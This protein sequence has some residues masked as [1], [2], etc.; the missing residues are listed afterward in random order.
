MG[1]VEIFR[2]RFRGVA[3][4]DHAVGG[5]SLNPA[6]Q[7]WRKEQNEGLPKAFHFRIPFVPA[8]ASGWYPSRISGLRQTLPA[9]D[10]SQNTGWSAC[11]ASVGRR[12]DDD[13]RPLDRQCFQIVQSLDP[14]APSG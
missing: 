10:Q 9:S 1:T 13:G 5:K 4:N 7:A 6:Q 2:P 8:M 3:G 14:V 12:A 11:S